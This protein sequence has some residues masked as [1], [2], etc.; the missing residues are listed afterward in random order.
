MAN[1]QGLRVL[2]TGATGG[3]GKA[4][5]ERLAREGATVLAHGRDRGRLD[6]LVKK[7]AGAEAF[8]ADLSSLADVRRLATEVTA[9]GPLDVLIDNA[10]VGFGADPKKR[11][12]SADGFEL[13]F[14]INYLAPFVLSRE[15]A[16]RRA[17]VNVASA[18]QL[19]LCLD[20]LQSTRR[21]DGVE[22]YR[23]SKL[24]LIMLTFDRAKETSV[25]CVALHPG[26]FLD[27]AMVRDAGIAPLGTAESGGDAVA[28]VLEQAL[29]G[30]TGRYFD[31]KREARALPSAY[32]EATRSKLRELTERLLAVS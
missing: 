20:D 16:P 19:E 7:L 2:V 9:A 14:A 13:H 21:Y 30:M 24:A 25:P 15:L 18:G 26:T 11:E 8:S 32:D 1:V 28:F 6:P 10:G 29:A 12:T 5:A 23:R 27:T 31:V 3:V 22:A 4:T 17:I